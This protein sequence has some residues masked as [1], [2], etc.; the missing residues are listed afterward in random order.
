MR[1]RADCYD[2]AQGAATGDGLPEVD[3]LMRGV[4]AHPGVEG[5]LVFNETGARRPT[6]SRASPP[7]T[8]PR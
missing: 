5:F 6:A 2:F 8:T 7:F 4:L 1:W 3:V